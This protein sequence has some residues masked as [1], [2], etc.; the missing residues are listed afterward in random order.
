[1]P[2]TAQR[3]LTIACALTATAASTTPAAAAETPRPL[4]WIQTD[5]PPPDNPYSFGA[6]EAI[7]DDD[8]W[9]VGGGRGTALAAHWDGTAW[10]TTPLPAELWYVDDV[11]ARASDD[12]WA[13]GTGPGGGHVMRW[14]GTAWADV[15]VPMPDPGEYGE[16]FMA[17]LEVLPGG[18]VW[19][20]GEVNRE[21][22]DERVSAGFT[23][24]LTGG[25][26]ALEE[27]PIP[28]GAR[29]VEY[30][31]IAAT[32]SG[33]VYTTGVKYVPVPGTGWTTSEPW[34]TRRDGAQWTDVAFPALPDDLDPGHVAGI[35]P[36]KR[37]R[38]V[39]ITGT[40]WTVD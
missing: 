20:T 17:D 27:L 28:D 13:L 4:P 18:E 26:W 7:A 19:A 32:R 11:R 9:A 35:A 21:I 16:V 33:T 5:T 23:L 40:A 39:W 31:G 25:A 36:D 15:P 38:G 3:L 8:V 22:K 34:I 37:G 2:S 6:V 10:T 14:D 1:M 12:V 29:D 24:H 30:T